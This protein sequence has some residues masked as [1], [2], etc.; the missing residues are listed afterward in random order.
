[1][2]GG[3]ISGGGGLDRER[4]RRRR[5]CEDGA[6]SVGTGEWGLDAE[7]TLLMV[8]GAVVDNVEGGNE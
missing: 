2:G 3:S 8:V 5:R 7:S 6:A 4:V 1:M